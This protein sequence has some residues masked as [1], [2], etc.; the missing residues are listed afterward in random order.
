[1]P[2]LDTSHV[3]RLGIPDHFVEH[4]ERGEL[5]ADLGLDAAGIAAACREL[6]ISS[7]QADGLPPAATHNS[8]AAWQSP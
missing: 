8:A 4:G 5:L 3:R 7:P 6:A 1:M 2:A